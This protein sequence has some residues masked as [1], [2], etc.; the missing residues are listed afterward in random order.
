M[1]KWIFLGDESKIIFAGRILGV[2]PRSIDKNKSLIIRRENVPIKRKLSDSGTTILA[3]YRVPPGIEIFIPGHV[4]NFNFGAAD[5]DRCAIFETFPF[6]KESTE[7]LAKFFEFGGDFLPTPIFVLVD[8]GQEP[9]AAIGLETAKKIFLS[10]DR[11]IEIFRDDSDIMKILHR[12]IPAASE[13]KRQIRLEFREIF[14]R[15]RDFAEDYKV[16]F[17]EQKSGGCMSRDFE[18]KIVGYSVAKGKSHLWRS[19]REAAFKLL[20]PPAK[21]GQKNIFTEFYRKALYQTGSVG[22][23]ASTVWNESEDCAGIEEKI[24]EKFIDYM[25]TPEKFRQ[26]FNA[27]EC[28]SERIYLA[29]VNG[30]GQFGGIAKEFLTRYETFI[31]REILKIL[32]SELELRLK[33]LQNINVDL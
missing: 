6:C 9:D 33:K 20:F 1:T 3:T 28:T 12:H 19:F 8:A 14:R 13:I 2:R 31:G 18:N 23:L 5:F 16:F 10:R 17:A 21:S 29:I 7:K 24:R 26:F 27:E 11:E 4:E 32:V 22:T 15:S 25:K 30:T